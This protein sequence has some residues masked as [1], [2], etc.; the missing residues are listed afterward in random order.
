[1]VNEFKLHAGNVYTRK[2]K[3]A[4]T[5]PVLVENEPLCLSGASMYASGNNVYIGNQAKQEFVL[6]STNSYFSGHAIRAYNLNLGTLY[7]KAVTATAYL[8]IMGTVRCV[9][10]YL[11]L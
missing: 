5:H 3:L 2:I 7:V 9:H 6:N 8:H 11:T 4:H 10:D 1:M